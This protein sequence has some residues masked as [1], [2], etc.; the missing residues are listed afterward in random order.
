MSELESDP[1]AEDD[2]G[3]LMYVR[4]SLCGEWMDVKPGRLHWISHGLCP[5]CHDKE[6]ARIRLFLDERRRKRGDA[7][8]P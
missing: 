2:S 4:C 5:V 6:M 8:A 7:P 3:A 1:Q